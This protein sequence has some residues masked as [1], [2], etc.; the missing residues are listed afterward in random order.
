MRIEQMKENKPVSLHNTT[1]NI[2]KFFT[3]IGPF[4]GLPVLLFGS[5]IL[6][7]VLENSNVN[8]RPF[9][10]IY[11]PK[12]AEIIFVKY[13]WWRLLLPI[14]EFKGSWAVNLVFTH[15]VETVIGA[16]NAWYLFN[17][18]LIITAF[19]I[20]WLVFKS[21]VF[22][23]TFSICM[24]FSTFLYH[25]YQVPGPVGFPL[26]VSFFILLLFIGYKIL[27][28]SNHKVF[29]NVLFF[30]TLSMTAIQYEGWLDFFVFIVLA[31]A[32]LFIIN[33]KNR[34]KEILKSLV[35]VSVILFVVFGVYMVIKM[36][37]A[38]GHTAG[39]ESD[40]IFNYP[41]LSPAIEDFLS[42]YFGNLYIV[43][44]S[45]LPPPFMASNALYSLGPQQL[46]DLQ[47]GY[48]KEFSYMVPMHY[49][50]L[51]RYYAGICFAVFAY[52]FVK[53]IRKAF[54]EYSPN[55]IALSLFMIMIG[56]GGPTHT[57][58]KFRPMN[59]VP[60]LGYHVIVGVLGLSL[61][62]A[63]LL[64]M[65][66]KMANKRW[67][68]ISTIA[69]TWTLI[70]YSALTRPAFLNDLLTYAG[71]RSQGNYPDPMAHIINFLSRFFK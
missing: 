68:A 34:N 53:I 62:I 17:W 28:G 61:L 9:L 25:T 38:N 4:M 1:T 36:K 43:I 30:I 45:F 44:T 39:T 51:W 66:Q 10:P 46:T 3:K 16:P 71:L 60:L 14:S 55:T 19:V 6:R 21:Y 23:Y 24:G 5:Y 59:S 12:L 31:I 2:K 49:I 15:W 54:K 8:I 64:M 32:F 26:L 18:I 22:S 35:S 27:Y 63:Y 40:V 33:I 70:F 52:F 29:W 37:Y 13:S 58:V 41:F 56:V 57:L 48:H 20:S 11:Y 67:I 69:G 47:Y 50:F 65:L 42:N 7:K